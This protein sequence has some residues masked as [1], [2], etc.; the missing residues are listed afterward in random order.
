VKNSDLQIETS[1]QG[2]VNWDRIPKHPVYIIHFQPKTGTTEAKHTLF[3]WESLWQKHTAAEQY[4][5]NP[6]F[7]K[8]SQIGGIIMMSQ[9]IGKMKNDIITPNW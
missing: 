3:F 6:F 9:A 8:L 7:G 2:K 5:E 1:S 4:P